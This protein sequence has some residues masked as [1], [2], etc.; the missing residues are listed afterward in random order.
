MENILKTIPV[1][2][3][4]EVT[5][6]QL[7]NCLKEMIEKNPEVAKK[8]L[9]I[10]VPQGM[11]FKKESGWN[12]YTDSEGWLFVQPAWEYGVNIA[13]SKDKVGICINY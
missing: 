3:K 8:A 6:E 5:V 13:E 1:A 9:Y 10:E 12:S 7:F 4:E 2:T 11:E